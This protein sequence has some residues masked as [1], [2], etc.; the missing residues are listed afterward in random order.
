VALFPRGHAGL[1]IED[2]KS[3]SLANR[4]AG[5]LTAVLPDNGFNLVKEVDVHRGWG[6]VYFVMV[7][8]GSHYEDA[9]PKLRWMVHEVVDLVMPDVRHRVKIVW[10]SES[11]N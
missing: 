5:A 8:S 11:S 9:H 4:V 7:H 6:D 2:M 3:E 1:S 10:A